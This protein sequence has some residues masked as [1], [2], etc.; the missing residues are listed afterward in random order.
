MPTPLSPAKAL[1]DEITR[2][3]ERGLE[4]G[5]LRADTGV[6]E[7]AR[8]QELL[9]RFL[10]APPAAV[11]DVGGGAGVY[12]CWLARLG[13][14]VHLVDP[15]PLHIEQ[16]LRASGTQPETRIA[17]IALGDARTL[18]LSDASVDAVLLLGPL[19][20]LTDRAERVHALREARRVG[21]PGA[22]VAAAAISRLAST[23]DGLRNDYLADATFAAIAERDRHDGQHRNPTGS[24]A[25]FTT[26]FFHAPEELRDEMRDAGLTHVATLAVEGVGWLL[27][28]VMDR[29]QD[30][31]RRELLMAALRALE[32][33]PS[34]LGASA[35]LLA[36]G[37]VT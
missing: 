13:Y 28:D 32:N 22:V 29:L 12:A 37:R 9:L 30:S 27:G 25:Y 2:Y 23:L 7:L 34:A 16:A 36:L 1:P 15:V 3:Y 14:V 6:L 4:A 31:S 26:A 33:E 20:H 11:A 8:T 18:P 17:S 21:R 24:P 10:P 19:Y 35:H 5:R